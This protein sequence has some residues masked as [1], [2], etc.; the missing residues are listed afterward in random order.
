MKIEH[1]VEFYCISASNLVEGT[2]HP[3][4]LRHPEWTKLVV[5][6]VRNRNPEEL[7]RIPEDCFK[8]RFYD[9]EFD[10]TF[11]PEFDGDVDAS[12]YKNKSRMHYT[13]LHKKLGLT[14][15]QAEQLPPTDHL[16]IVI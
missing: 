3:V 13:G 8:Y 11:V 12:K 14:K 6:S 9:R 16:D 4:K 2:H 1:Q 7:K 15:K 10:E 5:R